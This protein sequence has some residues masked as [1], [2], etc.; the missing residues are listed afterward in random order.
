MTAS[1]QQGTFITFEGIDGSGKTTQLE[2]LAEALRALGQTVVTTREPGGTAIG[3]RIR[4]LVLEPGR[5]KLSTEA[6]LAL[7]FA[8]RAQN[9]EEVIVPALDRGDWVL[10]DRF[11]DATDAYQGGGR[12]IDR[13][14]IWKL[15]ALLCRN[16]QP[17]LTFILD[18]DVELAL[19]RAR[20][21]LHATSSNEGRFEAE[22]IDFFRRVANAY[23]ER[24]KNEPKRCVL[25]DGSGSAGDVHRRIL[26][27]VEAQCGLQAQKK[28][29]G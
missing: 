14:L 11:T 29:E 18:V 21:R 2:M 10:C 1:G 23:Q 5:G 20:R 15:H 24:A 17:Q 16:L 6:E 26:A 19:A 7:L 27:S 12:G 25:V 9:I 8:S 22:S 13:G 28:S 3:D 4:S